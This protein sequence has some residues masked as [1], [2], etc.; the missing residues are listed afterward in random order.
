[1]VHPPF[2]APPPD[3][4]RALAEEQVPDNDGYGG[5]AFGGSGPYALPVAGEFDFPNAG[6]QIDTA[7]IRALREHAHALQRHIHDDG[8]RRASREGG[9]VADLYEALGR[10][11]AGQ[12]AE[13]GPSFSADDTW[14]AL[15]HLEPELPRDAWRR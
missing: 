4:L 10:E 6:A 7:Q 8:G 3:A 5:Y 12:G 11:S 13:V 1:M 15:Y 9:A 14:S 2:R